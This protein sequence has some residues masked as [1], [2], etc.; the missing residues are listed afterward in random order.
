MKWW[1]R[2]AAGLGMACAV[3]GVSLL[4]GASAFASPAPVNCAQPTYQMGVA[5][6]GL[7]AAQNLVLQQQ[8]DLTY[9]GQVTI[10]VFCSLNGQDL[11]EVTNAEVAITSTVPNVTFDGKPATTSNPAHI[12]LPLG[13]ETVTIAAPQSTLAVNQ[14]FARIGENNV[15]TVEAYNQEVPTGYGLNMNGNVFAATPEL[16]SL[17]LFGSG[18]VGLAGYVVMRRRARSK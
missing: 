13:M 3:A 1:S 18:A 16:D 11:G 12:D 14:F 10:R 4:G 8:P 17:A 15:V 6:M 5:F 7:S 2:A 9:Q